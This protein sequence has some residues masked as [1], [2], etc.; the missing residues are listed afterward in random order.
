MIAN[1]KFNGFVPTDI[2]P[3]DDAY[4]PSKNPISEE[5]WYFDAIFDNDYSLHSDFTMFTKNGRFASSAIEIYKNGELETQAI[6]RHLLKPFKISTDFPG[7]KLYD[8][9]I[10]SFDFERFKEMNE[11]VYNF[12]QKLDDFEINLNFVGTTKGWKIVTDDLSWTVAQPKAKV[13]GEIIT[14]GKKMKVNGIGYHDHNW[15]STFLT[16]FKIFGWYWGKI[17]SK[18]YNVTWANLMKNKIQ[19]Q[20]FAILNKDLQGFY[21]V[22]PENI[23]LKFDK[24]IRDHGRKIPTILNLKIN[25]IVKNIPISVDVSMEIKNIHFKSLLLVPYWRYHIKTNG[26]ISMDSHEEQVNETHIMEFFRLA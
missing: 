25:D 9:K 24:F 13:S 12:S 7:V 2:V 8:D 1:M 11:W 6:K 10:I 19:G 15:N 14:D 20:L 26:Y 4:H 5:W 16:F 23:S 22:N 21:S 17:T 3:K 18:T